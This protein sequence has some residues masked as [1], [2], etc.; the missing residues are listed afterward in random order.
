MGIGHLAGRFAGRLSGGQQQRMF[1]A[2][3]LV[4]EPELLVLD[5]PTTGIDARGRDEMLSLIAGVRAEGV[6]VVLATHEDRH[7]VDLADRVCAVDGTV[8]EVAAGAV[9]GSHAQE[10]HP[11]GTP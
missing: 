11:K 8:R 4:I 2:R 1:V 10:A 7:V 3:A 5:E 9:P 6:G